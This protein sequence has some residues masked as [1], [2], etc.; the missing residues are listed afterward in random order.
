MRR[1]SELLLGLS[2]VLIALL[3]PALPASAERIQ[4]GF[5]L[6]REGDVISE[7]LYVAGNSITIA[8]R[9]EGDVLAVAFGEIR[10][11]G[12]VTG[13][14]TALSSRLVVTGEVGGSVRAAAPEVSVTG[15]VGEDLFVA[16]IGVDTGAETSIG[17]DLL[18]WAWTADLAGRVGRNLE[19]QQRTTTIDAVV[20]GD[21]EVTVSSLTV[22]PVTDVAGDLS[23]RSEDD[24]E[25]GEGATVGGSLLHTRPLPLNVRVRALLILATVLAAAG[26]TALG[27]AVLWAAP[28]RS[29]RATR[30][31][32]HRPW[33]SLG[34]GLGVVAIPV[35]VAA[36][37]GVVVGLSPPEAG[38]P[39]LVVFLPLLMA[40][41]GLV[42]VGAFF[43]PVASVT[44]AGML[45]MPE[46]SSYAA[47]VAGMAVLLVV[48]FVPYLGPALVALVVVSGLGAWVA[49]V[50]DPTD[51][52]N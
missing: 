25:I 1:R 32:L 34:W 46:R 8:G 41:L 13:S 20:G 4:S 11:D 31:L 9:V 39:L 28:E 14:V 6:I 51:T 45:A 29:R 17:R 18:V 22:G 12:V 50:G 49:S 42:F 24:A 3:G 33:A 40:A 52:P 48:S 44:T 37:A 19:G 30:T 5:V 15:D 16:G 36:L 43:A 21:V 7:D 38:I 23:Y 2:L 35:V 27:I 10:I 26:T 47:F